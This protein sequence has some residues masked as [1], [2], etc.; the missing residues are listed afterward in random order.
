VR[1]LLGWHTMVQQNLGNVQP[2][3]MCSDTGCGKYEAGAK[4]FESIADY[5]SPTL[6]ILM[7]VATSV[8]TSLRAVIATTT[9]AY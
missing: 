9:V 8:G 4:P 3:K 6:Y 5:G 7:E 2:G 1:R